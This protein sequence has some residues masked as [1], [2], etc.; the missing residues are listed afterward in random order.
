[1]DVSLANQAFAVDGLQLREAAL[2]QELAFGAGE[3]AAHHGYLVGGQAVVAIRGHRAGKAH[4]HLARF[5]R[6]G[7]LAGIIRQGKHIILAAAHQAAVVETV[8][9]RM[10]EAR[11]VGMRAGTT[12]AD[13]FSA[14][15][16]RLAVGQQVAVV[17][18]P[19]GF[20][21][22]GSFGQVARQVGQELS[23]FGRG[24]QQVFFVSADEEHLHQG[25]GEVFGHLARAAE[26]APL[27]MYQ[28]VSLNVLH[29]AYEGL[30]L[31][32]A[33]FMKLS[34]A[35]GLPRVISTRPAQ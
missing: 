35:S 28:F 12:R 16:Q 4:R 27:N 32:V 29:R 20:E 5:A 17:L 13:G 14:R 6:H 11:V 22:I 31:E 24:R 10:D 9:V 1:M 21:R 8:V 2:G 23:A 33:I 7:L 25:A 3:V 15:R 19:D 18:H 34:P 26:D 30:K